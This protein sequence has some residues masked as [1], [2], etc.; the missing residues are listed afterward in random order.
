ML[1]T[2]KK[3]KKSRK[4]ASLGDNSY[5]NCRNGTQCPVP[6]LVKYLPRSR[7]RCAVNYP[8]ETVIRIIGPNIQEPVQTVETEISTD[9]IQLEKEN[10]II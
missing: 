10:E 6:V 1:T 5:L 7:K 3:K 8:D 4:L 9:S 2:A